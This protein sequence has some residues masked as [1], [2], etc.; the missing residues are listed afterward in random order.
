MKKLGCRILMLVTLFHF[1]CDTFLEVEPPVSSIP[2]HQVFED[3]ETAALAVA[4][5]YNS[6]RSL[7]S[8][9]GG[10]TSGIASL[11]GLSADELH[12]NLQN[13]PTF[14]EFE[15]NSLTAENLYVLPMWTSMYRVIYEANAILEGL[16][17]STGVS[18]EVS[19][20]LQGEALLVRAFCYFYLVNCFGDVPL[21]LS[22]DYHIN[23]SVARMPAADVYARMK[24]DLLEAETLLSPD[25]ITP[26]RVRPNSFAATAM[27]ARVYLFTGDWARAEEKASQV[28]SQT[29]LYS[30]PNTLSSV[31]KT[32]SQE[33]I[34]QLW[35]EHGTNEGDT[36]SAE[37]SGPTNNVLTKELIGTFEPN[38][39]RRASWVASTMSAT[40]TT[41]FASKYSPRF[42]DVEID[43]YAVVLRLAEQFLIRADA[44]LQQ[45]KKSLA[46]A[47]V[48]AIRFRA[49][50]PLIQTT[51]PAIGADE[52][53]DMI[54]KER[55]LEFFTEWG[56]RW[57]DLKRLDRAN[58]TLGD[59]PGWS[60]ND[61]L[62]PIPAAEIR[63]N[64]NLEPQNPGY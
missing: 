7:T 15:T 63:I 46:I 11:A 6:L 5:M 41:Y 28:I 9:A 44:R 64:P 17:A 30:L 18:L 33:A 59:K 49:G 53:M 8:F 54:I 12:N 42:L 25:Y 32:A 21:I 45:N 47:D 4:G 20:Q 34:W 3:D 43:E 22:T 26:G 50:L 13:S 35:A 29:T 48:D 27:L 36:F 38:D 52:L 55:R 61:Q 51:N 58:T 62:Y 57:F 23:A 1:S 31:F 10:G 40:D 39:K 19:K 56:H 14:I 60:P 24:I 2:S 37:G 16:A